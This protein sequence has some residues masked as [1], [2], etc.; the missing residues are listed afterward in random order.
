MRKS[1]W[2]QHSTHGSHAAAAKVRNQLNAGLG[3]Y[4]PRTAWVR[5]ITATGSYVVLQHCTRVAAVMS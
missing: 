1:P 2:I 4:A 3:T 5:H